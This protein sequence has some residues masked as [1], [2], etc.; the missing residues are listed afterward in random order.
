VGD[1]FDILVNNAAVLLGGFDAEVVRRTLAVNFYGALHV[2]ERLLPRLRAGGRIVMVSSDMG[3]LSRVGPDVRARFDSPDLDREGLLAL[4][5][6]FV[7]AVAAGRHTR[8]GWPSNAYTVS[9]LGLNALTR[10]LARELA[11][12]AGHHCERGI[13]WMGPHAHGRDRG[14]SLT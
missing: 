4:M 14:T 1:G 9:K 7:D 12:W 5:A 8:R 10:V 13:P 2:T 11:G 6:S 3:A